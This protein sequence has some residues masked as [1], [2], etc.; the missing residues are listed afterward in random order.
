MGT[1]IVRNGRRIPAALRTLP[2]EPDADITGDPGALARHEVATVL[3]CSHPPF[4]LCSV[5]IAP[6]VRWRGVELSWSWS[7]QDRGPAPPGNRLAGLQRDWSRPVGSAAAVHVVLSVRRTRLRRALPEATLVSW[8]LSPMER[9]CGGS[10][11][12]RPASRHGADAPPGA[13]GRLPGA[14][15][16][17][18]RGWSARTQGRRPALPA[19]ASS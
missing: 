17:R 18:H 7:E 8:H 10:D 12:R 14:R 13:R 1:A 19:A 9:T 5:H 11:V 4:R 3:G 15:A 2:V 6:T 16:R